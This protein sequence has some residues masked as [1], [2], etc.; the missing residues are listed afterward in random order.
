MQLKFGT[1]TATAS[2]KHDFGISKVLSAI[3]QIVE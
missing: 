3:A 2:S 1:A